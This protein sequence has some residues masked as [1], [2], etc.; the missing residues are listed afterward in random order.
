VKIPDRERLTGFSMFHRQGLLAVERLVL[1]R[2]L[3][4]RAVFLLLAMAA[5]M[6]TST[7]RVWISASELAAEHRAVRE[8][9]C[10]SVQLLQRAG[11][12][13]RC[14]APPLNKLS[15]GE[16]ASMPDP[17]FRAP[18]S[19]RV[20]F[21]I[22]PGL[23]SVGGQTRRAWALDRFQSAI[24]DRLTPFDR[25]LDAIKAAAQDRVMAKLAA[26]AT[27]NEVRAELTA[28]PWPAAA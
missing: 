1:Q 20:Y 8:P 10:N 14:L 12:V 15:A 27:P 28:V 6:N 26:G 19:A 5:R 11:L 25:E 21:L 2:D 17:A 7:G 4:T 9:V 22:H 3:T 18:L 16:R 24:G 23:A 13:V